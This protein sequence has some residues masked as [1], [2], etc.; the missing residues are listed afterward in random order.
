M[1]TPESNIT[2]YEISSNGHFVVLGMEGAKNLITLQ[3]RGPT[4]SE[5]KEE[6]IYGDT[7]NTGKIFELQEC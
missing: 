2:S 1:Y 3:L 7:E 5:K 4:A 6:K